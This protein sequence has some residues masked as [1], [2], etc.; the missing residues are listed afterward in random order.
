[1]EES[2]SSKM[3]GQGGILCS[4][5]PL[6][7]TVLCKKGFVKLGIFSAGNTMQRWAGKSSRK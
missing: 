1:M 5:V 6:G 3:S 2:G 7:D 4:A